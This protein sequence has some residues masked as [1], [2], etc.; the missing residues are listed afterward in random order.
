MHDVVLQGIRNL[1]AEAVRVA[2]KILPL[3]NTD[4][5]VGRP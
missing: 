5:L 3:R 2:V 1:A 4:P